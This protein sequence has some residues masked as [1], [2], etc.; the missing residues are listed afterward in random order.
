VHAGRAIV[1][2]AI[3]RSAASN[4]IFSSAVC[5]GTRKVGRAFAN[6]VLAAFA[7]AAFAG[8]NSVHAAM[9]V[10]GFTTA[11][12]G[13]Y[14]RFLNDS[15]FIGNPANWPAGPSAGVSQFPWT[16]VGRGTAGRWGTI[17]SPSYIISANHFPPFGT[18]RFYYTNDPNGLFEDHTIVSSQQ[19]PGGDVWLGK[20]DAP[21]SNKIAISPLLLLPH[22]SDYSGL[23]IHTFGLSD[24]PA[25][26]D[27]INGNATMVRLGTNQIDLTAPYDNGNPT[28]IQKLNVSGTLGWAFPYDY[29]PTIPNPSLPGQT[30]EQP[31]ESFLNFGDSGAPSFFLY[32]GGKPALVGTHWFNNTDTTLYSGDTYLQKYVTSIQGAMVGE[33]LTTISPVL[34]DLNLDG[35]VTTSDIQAM[36]NALA[37]LPAFKSL[38][39]LSDGYLLDIAD[40]NGD[41][42]V[43]NA[44]VNGLLAHFTAVTGRGS[45]GPHAV[46]EPSALVLMFSAFLGI[47]LFRWFI[48]SHNARLCSTDLAE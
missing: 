44:D 39:G 4:M 37:N 18:I 8:L 22:E 46:P 42:A 29:N 30:I 9:T 16:G 31:N 14:D 11:T 1:D 10:E 19:I 5:I 21:V 23:G 20:L 47:L 27:P 36:L 13:K 3:V 7:I 24:A 12:A 17:I 45:F 40:M 35:A 26:V 34:G 15:S 48:A 41:G 2:I 38:H 6:S 43:T 28:V 25:G 32:S 33:T